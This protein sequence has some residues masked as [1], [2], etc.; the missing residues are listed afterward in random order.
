MYS[1]EKILDHLPELGM[2]PMILIVKANEGYSAVHVTQDDYN[3]KLLMEK[4]H[5]AANVLKAVQKLYGAIR[6]KRV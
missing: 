6:K 2:D 3:P 1:I 4:H 5:N